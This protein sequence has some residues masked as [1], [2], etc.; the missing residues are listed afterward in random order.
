M[1]HVRDKSLHISTYSRYAMSIFYILVG[2]FHFIIPNTYLKIIPNYIPYHLELVIISGFA[3]VFLGSLLLIKKC[4]RQASWGIILLLT[5][6]IPVNIYIQQSDII[7][8]TRIPWITW[9]RIP[10]LLF[11]M[12]WAF[13]HT[14]EN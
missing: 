8:D 7:L 6:I 2:S 10:L 11:L 3:E 13:Y 9:G 1:A 14:R 12:L 5:T 4:V